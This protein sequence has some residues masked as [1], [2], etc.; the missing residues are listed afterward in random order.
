MEPTSLVRRRQN[1]LFAVATQ[2]MKPTVQQELH[3]RASVDLRKAVKP[4]RHGHMFEWFVV[5]GLPAPPASR[6]KRKSGFANSKTS[7]SDQPQVLYTY[8]QRDKEKEEAGNKKKKQEFAEPYEQILHFCFPNGVKP[9]KLSTHVREEEI[10]RVLFSRM[11]ELTDEANSFI[12]TMTTAENVLLY[13]ICIL[14]PDIPKLRASFFDTIDTT[15]TTAAKVLPALFQKKSRLVSAPRCY[16]LITRFPF[17]KLHFDVLSSMI[18]Y[19]RTYI[20]SLMAHTKANTTTLLKEE[21]AKA[22]QEVN[23]LLLTYHSLTRTQLK[24]I[25]PEKSTILAEWALPLLFRQLGLKEVMILLRALLQECK[26]LFVCQMLGTL[27]A[28]GLGALSL[29]RPYTWQGTFIPILPDYLEECVDSPVPYIIGIQQLSASQKQHLSSDCLIFD[30]NS[31]SSNDRTGCEMTLPKDLPLHALPDEDSLRASLELHHRNFSFQER[32]S[33]SP[34]SSP[35]SSRSSSPSLCTSASS[36][37]SPALSPS[38]RSSLSSSS[39]S[40]ASRSSSCSSLSSSSLSLSSPSPHSSAEMMEGERRR[41]IASI[42]QVLSILKGY[43]YGLIEEIMIFSQMFSQSLSLSEEEEEQAPSLSTNENKSADETKTKK[44]TEKMQVKKV[45]TKQQD[46]EESKELLEAAFYAPNL[47]DFSD[48]THLSR[49]VSFFPCS[50]QPFMLALLHTQQFAVF[51]ED[52]LDMMQN[53]E[54][55]IQKLC[56]QEISS[57][58]ARH[59]SAFFSSPSFSSPPSSSFSSS[60]MMQPRRKSSV[61]IYRRNTFWRD[62]K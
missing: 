42:Q 44:T 48:A 11:E 58:L 20:T 33:F 8:P 10:Y 47:M 21:K 32:R 54:R 34:H 6:E 7:P 23:Q 55:F 36:L 46:Q 61:L 50:Q 5:V 56:S 35:S 18:A 49:L 4:E 30:L 51:S 25:C 12:F 57:L 52:L 19:E 9:S 15:T 27:S 62:W 22:L 43:N 26:V 3:R 28:L 31:S 59:S 14:K 37:S 39:P 60:S 40:A 2:D 29:L 24:N 16:C 45:R 41:N 13:G 17:F 1:R 38:S 53:K